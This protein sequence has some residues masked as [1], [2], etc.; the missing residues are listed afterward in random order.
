MMIIFKVIFKNRTTEYVKLKS[1]FCK[2]MFFTTEKY[3]KIFI[4]AI[5]FITICSFSDVKYILKVSP[6]G[7]FNMNLTSVHKKHAGL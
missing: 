3:R 1:K 7:R 6:S 4:L 2:P 5:V